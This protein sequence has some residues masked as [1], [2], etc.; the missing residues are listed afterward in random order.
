RVVLR[1]G[2]AGAGTASEGR[3][4]GVCVDGVLL[5]RRVRVGVLLRLADLDHVLLLTIA[6]AAREALAAAALL[7]RGCV[8]IGLA[9]VRRISVGLVVGVL[10]RRARAGALLAFAKDRGRV[11]GVDGGLLGN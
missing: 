10:V 2:A 3:L 11:G 6:A 5:R 4:R 7:R 1:L 9:V 8:L